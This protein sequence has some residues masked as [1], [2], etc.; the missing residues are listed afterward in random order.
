MT[1]KWPLLVL[2]TVVLASCAKDDLSLNPAPETPP[3]VEQQAPLQRADINRFV[4]RQL[5]EHNRFEWSMGDE[6]LLYSASVQTDSVMAVGYQ[7]AG[8]QNIDQRMHEINIQDPVWRK[9]RTALITYIVEATNREF[10]GKNYTAADLMPF[11]DDLYLPAID[12]KIFSQKIITD[13]RAMPEVRYVEPMGYGSE[14]ELRSD[15]GCGLEPNFGIPSADYS[16]I[17]PGVKQSW[18]LTEMNVPNAWSQSTGRNIKVA[19]L[20]T[21]TSPNQPKLGSQ[22]NQGY[23]TSRSITRL[24]TYVSG[25][26]TSTPDGPNDQCGH[27]TQMAGLIAAPRG[28]DGTNVGVAYNCN[29]LAIRVT[30]DV[31]INGSSEK[32]GVADGLTIAANDGAVKVISMSIGDV[33]SNSRVADAVRYA[34]GKGKLIFAAAGT[35]L[36]WTSWWG[37]IFP[38]SMN[39][40]VAVT[41]VKDGLPLVRCNTCHDGDKV[42]FVAVMQRRNDDGRTALTLAMSGNQPATVGGSSAATA[43]TAGIAALVWATNPSMTR[44]Q[45]LTRLKNASQFYPARDGNF[46]WGKI[47]AAAAVAGN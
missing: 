43:T 41:G 45:V 29:L 28:T 16:T 21:G 3:G 47:D 14:Q 23:S 11:A 30:G 10:P 15:S 1:R 24:G 36:S 31:V 34:Y 33:F 19:L 7:P 5:Q 37:V 32:R 25:W 22:F 46:G 38:A 8:F 12:I 39:E 9:A 27:G 44:D 42:D 6:H 40:T 35:S 18:H 4:L 13:L 26:F 20:D 2:V 17:A